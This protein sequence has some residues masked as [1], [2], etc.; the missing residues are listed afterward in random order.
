MTAN[1]VALLPFRS[2]SKRL[3]N[4]NFL[5]VCGIPLYLHVLRNIIDS[6]IFD[7][8]IIATDEP[9]QVESDIFEHRISGPVTVHSRSPDT[10]SDFAPTELVMLEIIKEFDLKPRDW[11]L[12]FQVT[13]PFLNERYFTEISQIIKND[14]HDSIVS[15]VNQKRFLIDDICTPGFSRPRTQE[16]GESCLE[17]GLFWGIKVEAFKETGQ[18]I[19]LNPNIVF[20]DEADDFDIDER[21]QFD[22]A[23]GQI[24][25]RVFQTKRKFHKKNNRGES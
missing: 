21:W 22:V 10:S 23:K 25:E 4:K 7:S 16:L 2:N 20:I 24:A 13:N 8:V 11:L 3:K 5:P 14:C 9:R 6:G 12:L 18:R 17:T 15:G 19:G 1:N